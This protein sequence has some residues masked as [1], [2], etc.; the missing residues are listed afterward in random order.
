MQKKRN[1]DAK[2]GEHTDE[3][4]QKKGN[5]IPTKAELFLG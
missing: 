5:M 4:M 2:D 1:I 3:E